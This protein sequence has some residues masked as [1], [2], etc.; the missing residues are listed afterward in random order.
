MI[1]LLLL[2][3]SFV[4]STN[5]FENCVSN[6]H[7]RKVLVIILFI[8]S[9]LLIFTYLLIHQPFF[10]H[11][12]R[13]ILCVIG[14]FTSSFWSIKNHGE[15][16]GIS[17]SFLMLQNELVNKN[18]ICCYISNQVAL[19]PEFKE[20][21]FSIWWT[22]EQSTFTFFKNKSI[23]FSPFHHLTT[24]LLNLRNGLTGTK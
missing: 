22:G 21:I 20:H 9:L 16:G 24:S 7:V 18:C 1:L 2:R 5:N 6:S 3:L 13:Q 12:S 10:V 19:S 23:F 4:K 15:Q 14:L 11:L 17:P 8:T